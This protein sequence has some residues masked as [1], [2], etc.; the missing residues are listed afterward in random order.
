MQTKPQEAA[1][2]QLFTEGL[3]PAV[4]ASVTRSGDPAVPVI[5]EGPYVVPLCAA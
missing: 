5:P 2:A 1:T 4:A 3:D